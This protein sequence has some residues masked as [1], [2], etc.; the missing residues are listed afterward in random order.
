MSAGS[1]PACMPNWTVR[2]PYAH[3]HHRDD[4]GQGLPAARWGR[5]TE[6]ARPVA[7]S[8]DQKPIGCAL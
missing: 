1:L 4:E 8:A 3:L 7:A 5:N 6:V 2:G